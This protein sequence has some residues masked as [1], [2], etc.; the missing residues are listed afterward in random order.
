MHLLLLHPFC[1]QLGWLREALCAQLHSLRYRYI[2]MQIDWWEGHI[3][4]PFYDQ[5]AIIHFCIILSRE[6]K[7]YRAKISA[8]THTHK[9]FC[10]LTMRF[11]SHAVRAHVRLSE[12]ERNGN[13]NADRTHFTPLVMGKSNGINSIRPV[14]LDHTYSWGPLAGWMPPAGGALYRGTEGCNLSFSLSI[15]L[16]V[17][18][19]WFLLSNRTLEYDQWQ[20]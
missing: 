8:L 14:F 13:E 15:S 3:Y 10:R 12:W 2:H 5:S 4:C 19:F 9:F 1:T 11:F 6:L 7:S 20:L 17:C 16:H 18:T